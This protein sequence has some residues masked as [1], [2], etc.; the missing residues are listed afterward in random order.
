M[1]ASEIG[2]AT[3]P[4]SSRAD[5][6]ELML[7]A[8]TDDDMLT[9]AS[10]FILDEFD[11]YYSESRAIPTLAKQAF[12]QREP[13]RS[14]ALSRRRLAIYGE[15]IHAI[16]ARLKRVYPL[17]SRDEGLWETIEGRYL[18]L[19]RGRYEE[20]LALAYVNSVRRVIFEDEWQPVDY[21]FGVAGREGAIDPCAVLRRFEPPL[22]PD[23]IGQILRSAGFE[24]PFRDLEADAALAS[25]RLAAEFDGADVA[26]VEMVE[27][28]F[29]RNRGAY[30]VGR[31]SLANGEARPLVFALENGKSGVTLDA[32]L[33]REAEVHNLFSTTLANFHVTDAR[34]HELAAFLKTLMPRRP[35]GLHYSGIG[36]NHVGKVAVMQELAG[37]L[38]AT[39]EKIA[40]AA[41]FRGTVAV[42]F[43]APS[44]AYVLK[45]IRDTPAAGYKWGSF[46][47]I[48]AVLEKYRQVHEINR[49]GSMLDNMIYRRVRLPLAWFDPRLALELLAAASRTVSLVGKHLVFRHLIAQPKMIPLPIYLATASREQAETAMLSLGACIKNNAAGGV[50]NKDLDA[51]N[52][53]VSRFGKVYLFDYDAVEPLVDVKIR[54][55]LGREDGEEDVPD[56]VFE[57]GVIF[58]PEEIEAGFMLDDRALRRVFRAA[59]GDLLTTGY[60]EGMQRA[61]RRGW[62][63]KAEVYPDET[64]LR[65]EP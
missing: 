55:N 7:R 11:V 47:G 10:R 64:R 60:W 21:S 36:F 53:G 52:Y 23:R 3:A 26:A 40:T 44:S 25:T 32:V 5:Y 4:G 37:E 35:L 2:P 61:L 16:A 6:V 33:T 43:S 24:T 51:R 45:V 19:V 13:A 28:A 15:S 49:T 20:D 62:V 65:R 14:V 12:E 9:L 34:Y 38:A 50:F 54:T 8:R 30:L 41:G 58:L 56:W 18:P 48:E 22:T 42:G 57:D 63:P 29:F 39:G 27:A 1:A 46:A 31:A 59:H 17:L